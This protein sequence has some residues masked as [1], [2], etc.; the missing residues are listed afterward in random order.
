MRSRKLDLL[1]AAGII[2][3]GLLLL[4]FWAAAIAVAVL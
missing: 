3:M 2:L 1:K 4:A